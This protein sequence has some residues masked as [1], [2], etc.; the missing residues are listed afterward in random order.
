MA[1][2]KALEALNAVE[3]LEA[4]DVCHSERSEESIMLKQLN[5]FKEFFE[6][7]ISINE[8]RMSKVCPGGQFYCFKLLVP[9]Y[10]SFPFVFWP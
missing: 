2:E 7:R 3:A 6:Y 1:G 8:L 9:G 10:K 5:E 4:L